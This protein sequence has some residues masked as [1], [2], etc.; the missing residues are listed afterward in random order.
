MY[1]FNTIYICIICIIY[2]L[3]TLY[4]HILLYNILIII[5]IIEVIVHCQCEK[6]QATRQETAAKSELRVFHVST[7]RTEQ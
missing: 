3:C 4:I 7:W 2:I 5:Y 6:T 1:I